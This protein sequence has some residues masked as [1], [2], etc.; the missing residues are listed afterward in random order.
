MDIMLNRILSL[1]ETDET[2]KPKHGAKAK[3]A[4]SIGY[5]SGDI[6]SMWEKGSSNS[7]IKKLHEISTKY[8]VSLE[9]L[10]GETDDPAQKKRAHHVW[11]ALGCRNS[12]VGAVQ[13]IAAGHTG[14]VSCAS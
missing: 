9:W 3:F 14:A 13:E 5:D 2:G 8:N 6:V 1:L 4:R 12:I 10:R 7:Y 11:C